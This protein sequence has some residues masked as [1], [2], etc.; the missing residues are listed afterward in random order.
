MEE[1]GDALVINEWRKLRQKLR[2]K[3]YVHVKLDFDFKLLELAPKGTC[4][5]QER[6]DEMSR[7][8]YSSESRINEV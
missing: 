5:D 3:N 2:Q 7:A 8:L 6:N 1:W 4:S